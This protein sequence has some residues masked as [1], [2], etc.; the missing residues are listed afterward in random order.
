MLTADYERFGFPKL[1]GFLLKQSPLLC[2]SIHFAPSALPSL[3]FEGKE[4][5]SK[6]A[7]A[8]A[9]YYCMRNKVLCFCIRNLMSFASIRETV[10]G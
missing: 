2:T 9:L 3:G 1:T 5:R 4:D 10:A 6:H 8:H 7:D